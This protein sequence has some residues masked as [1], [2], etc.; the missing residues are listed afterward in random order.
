ME[1]F[2]GHICMI[3]V[4]LKNP[5]IY[6]V[7]CYSRI[8]W[9]VKYNCIFSYNC[10]RFFFPIFSVVLSDLY[11]SVLEYNLKEIA[12]AADVAQLGYVLNF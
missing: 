3:I 8:C 2:T 9:D 6:D 10:F 12:Y 7:L 11:L 1:R 4:M 5:P